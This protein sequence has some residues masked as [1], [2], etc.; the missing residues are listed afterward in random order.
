M[1]RFSNGFSLVLLCQSC[2]AAIDEMFNNKLHIIGGVGIGI[3]IIMVSLWMIAELFGFFV[4]FCCF[5]FI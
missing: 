5:A 1:S 2:P 4:Q 3:G